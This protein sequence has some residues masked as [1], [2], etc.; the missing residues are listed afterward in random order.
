MNIGEACDDFR[1]VGSRKYNLHFGG[2]RDLVQAVREE[3]VF[4][5]LEEMG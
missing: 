3:D 2:A 4:I 5:R 1:K